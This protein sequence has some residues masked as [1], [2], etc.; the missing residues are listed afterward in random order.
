M[1]LLIALKLALKQWRCAVHFV[2]IQNCWNVFECMLFDTS[3]DGMRTKHL[4]LEENYSLRGSIS[5]ATNNIL[6]CLSS[7]HG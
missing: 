1:K 6:T 3:N 2:I 7:N 4:I 5:Y